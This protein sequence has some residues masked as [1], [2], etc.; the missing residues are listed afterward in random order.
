MPGRQNLGH[1]P[2]CSI[3]SPLLHALLI[4]PTVYRPQQNDREGLVCQGVGRPPSAQ[5]LRPFPA[6]PAW[7]RWRHCRRPPRPA[8]RGTPGTAPCALAQAQR[9]SVGPTRSAT[10]SK[11]KSAGADDAVAGSRSIWLTQRG[12]RNARG[13][14]AFRLEVAACFAFRQFKV[15]TKTDADPEVTPDPEAKGQGSASA[16]ADAWG[17]PMSVWRPALRPNGMPSRKISRCTQ[18]STPGAWPGAS[19]CPR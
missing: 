16:G 4:C 9:Q 12:E 14:A 2:M 3:C 6:Q 15:Q 13:M 7:L 10:T 19:W 8:Q 5:P 18:R 1:P 11:L 17:R